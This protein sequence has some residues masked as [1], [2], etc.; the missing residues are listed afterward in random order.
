VEK[1]QP[2][3]RPSQESSANV[4]GPSKLRK[5][6]LKNKGDPQR[7]FQSPPTGIKGPLTKLNFGEFHDTQTIQVKFGPI[8]NCF[9]RT[10][11]S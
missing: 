7:D 9:S 5:V 8:N 6:K 11:K 10:N 1:G 4:E 3:K 2:E